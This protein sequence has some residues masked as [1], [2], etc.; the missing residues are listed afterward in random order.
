MRGIDPR[1]L[2]DR[3]DEWVHAAL[4]RRLHRHLIALLIILITIYL[5]HGA[6]L[7][8]LTVGWHSASS[9]VDKEEEYA[10]LR[11]EARDYDALAQWLRT[12]SGQEYARSVMLKR[13]EQGE[14]RVFVVPPAGETQ[15]STHA[16][17]RAWVTACEDRLNARYQRARRV[18]QRWATDPPDG[19]AAVPRRA[20]A[21]PTTTDQATHRD[22][23]PAATGPRQ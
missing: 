12:P 8:P 2:R 11:Q 7:L 13:L 23:T 3:L 18:F 5:T 16:G 9:L 1:R 6:V 10:R 4:P 14:Q 17:V 15:A 19:T 22:A 20:Q 21:E